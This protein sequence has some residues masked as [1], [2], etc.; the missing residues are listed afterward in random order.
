MINRDLLWRP[1]RVQDSRQGEDGTQTRDRVPHHAGQAGCER[2]FAIKK[3]NG[4][5]LGSFDSKVLVGSDAGDPWHGLLEGS[6]LHGP[7]T[8]PIALISPSC[9]GALCR[10][11]RF[12][13]AGCADLTPT[14][15]LALPVWR[16]PR[17]RPVRMTRAR[18]LLPISGQ[19]VMRA[20]SL[21]E[22][23]MASNSFLLRW[24]ISDRWDAP[25]V[26]PQQLMACAPRSTLKFV[27]SN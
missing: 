16:C 13:I 23:R 10:R 19:I 7:R 20:R 25:H 4:S 3:S 6:A 1:Y 22:R 9:Q 14:L 11:V 27:H 26:T 12:K 24:Q 2:N 8:R 21:P 5:A 17:H 18:R 15:V